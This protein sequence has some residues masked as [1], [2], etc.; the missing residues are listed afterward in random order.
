[1][2]HLVQRLDSSNP[3]IYLEKWGQTPFPD[4]CRGLIHQ[5]HLL[6]LFIKMIIISMK[7]WEGE[8]VAFPFIQ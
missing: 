7:K 6:A 4:H 1:M 8:K 3:P 5:A 2:I